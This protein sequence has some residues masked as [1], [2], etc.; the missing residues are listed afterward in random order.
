MFHELLEILGLIFGA[1]LLIISMATGLYYISEAIE[2]HTILTIKVIRYTT[3]GCSILHLLLLFEGL[4]LPRTLFSLFCYQIYSLMLS[5][6]PRINVTGILFISSCLLAI[7]DHAI[8]FFYFVNNHKEFS[9]VASFFGILV[10]LLP[11]LYFI[12]LNANDNTLP[13]FESTEK[14]SIVKMIAAVLA[15]FIGSE[16]VSKVL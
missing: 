15:T 1:S 3:I 12:S 16:R 13:G 4:S 11:F 6:F 8:W 5:S 7:S 9:F 10:W 2:E 14:N